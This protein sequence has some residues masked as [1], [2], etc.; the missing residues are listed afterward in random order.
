[1]ITFDATQQTIVSAVS[2]KIFWGFTVVTTGA[3]TYRWSTVTR[4]YGGNAYTFR[5]IPDSFNGVE[6][7]RNQSEMGLQAP[8]ELTFLV[9]NPANTLTATD[10]TDADLLLQLV[11]SD[12]TNEAVIRQFRFIVRRA[13]PQMQ[14]LRF[15]CVDY[16]QR[17]LKGDYP[18]TRLVKDIFPNSAQVKDDNVCVPEP[19]G[20]AYVPLRS[21]YIPTFTS[22]TSTAISAVASSNGSRCKLRTASSAFDNFEV[23]RTTPISGFTST[24][25][26]QSAIVLARSSTEMEYAENAGFVAEAVGDSVTV[27]QGSRAYV[28]G[29]TSLTYTLQKV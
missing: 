17:Y 3:T 12:Y 6:L 9:T 26:N 11:M 29:S 24:A 8:N 5:I 13:E 14:A 23:G 7:N 27:T 2:K 1:M 16:L 19:Y 22:L 28:L 25:N 10:F 4:S 20:V 18:N 15:H 21:V